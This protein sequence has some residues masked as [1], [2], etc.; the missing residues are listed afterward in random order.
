MVKSLLDPTIEYTENRE[1]DLDDKDME[2]ELYETEI[3]KTD[4]IFALGKPKYTYIDSNIIFYPIYLIENDKVRMQIGIYEILSSRQENYI[5]SE[6]EI[7][8]YKLNK[9]LLY[10]FAYNTIKNNKPSNPTLADA[11]PDADI[12]LVKSPS[13]KKDDKKTNKQSKPNHKWINKYMKDPNYGITDTLPDGNC[14]FSVLKLALEE[15]D[16]KVSIDEMREVLSNKVDEEFFLTNKTLYESL[17]KEKED[18]STEIKN[19]KKR[20]RT[21]ET[22]T[23]ESVKDR[24]LQV[25]YAKQLTQMKETQDDLLKQRNNIESNFNSFKFMENIDNLSMLK[26]KIKTKDFWAETWSI[27]TLEKEYNI[28]VIILSEENYKD[29]DLYNILQ[30]GDNMI[31]D[32]SAFEPSFYVLVCFQGN[33]YQ[34]IT[35]N[36][37]K[38]FDFSEIPEEIKTLVSD[39]CLEKIAGPY[40]LISE[41]VD[42]T[43]NKKSL[44]NKADAYINEQQAEQQAE[45]QVDQQVDQQAEQPEET[46]SDLYNNSTVFRFYSKSSDKPLP[47]KGQ[48]ESLGGEGSSAY[49]ELAKIPQWRKKLSNF[50]PAE[51]MLDNHR[52]LS[53]EHYYQGSKFKKS[54]KDFYLQFSLDSKDS[55]IARDAGMA[56]SAGGKSGKYKGEQIRP[57]HI[58]IDSDFF[59]KTKE[60][61]ISRGMIEMEN[62][63]RAKFTQN[64]DLKQLLIE[65][66][67]AK[68]EHISRGIPPVPF[69]NLMR[70]RREL[71]E[72]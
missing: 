32:N 55:S 42:Y 60:Q 30:C 56:K 43:L 70:V 6:G 25:S 34:L 22:K 31:N 54:N 65:T 57:K 35:Y 69:Y 14:F 36:D 16:Q 21:L 45:Q 13:H 62:A 17:K 10:S 33:H 12:E 20:Y 51:F 8:V 26:L 48:G 67:K 4:I 47:G 11:D 3:F 49:S 68:L 46:T 27:T 64:A 24:N 37:K 1:R 7:D 53:V 19:I 28:K 38:S 44:S 18:I 59:T 5:D 66:K 72:K 39:K 61:K 50:W 29:G 41:F 71:Q 15:R 52:W 63:M 2:S 23:K 40:S 9:P 58:V